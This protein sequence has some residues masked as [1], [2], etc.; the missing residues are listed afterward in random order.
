MEHFFTHTV[1]A[2]HDLG[3]RCVSLSRR[4]QNCCLCKTQ[5]LARPFRTHSKARQPPPDLTFC[6]LH[7]TP[8]LQE[9]VYR[10]VARL[11]LNVSWVPE[12][13]GDSDKVSD[14][15]SLASGKYDLKEVRMEPNHWADQLVAEYKTF[16]AKIACCD[17]SPEAL[18]IMWENAAMASA[19]AIIAGFARVRKCT[20]E[21]RALMSLDVQVVIGGQKKMAP[22]PAFARLD[23]A[24]RSADTYIKAF[25]LP[26]SEL[27]HWAQTHP[28]YS[29]AH[30]I[31]LVNQIAFAFK[32]N[33]G[34]A[35]DLVEKIERGAV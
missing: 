8:L 3:V 13:V 27:L 25:Y 23:M 33:R 6:L 5:L 14:K 15:F 31:A 20:L 28:E 24:M 19:E 21:G 26:E 18:T 16:G 29:P 12:A 10:A 22:Q 17:L 35:K 2:S 34:Q 9:H 11:L 32:W 1:D 4:F 30:V 7:T